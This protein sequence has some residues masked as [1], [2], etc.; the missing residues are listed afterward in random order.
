MIYK[1][2]LLAQATIR[3]LK[4]NFNLDYDLVNAALISD[5]DRLGRI[6]WEDRISDPIDLDALDRQAIL[7]ARFHELTAPLND[8]TKLREFETDFKDWIYHSVTAAVRANEVLKVFAGPQVSQG[9]FRRLCAETAEEGLEQDRE[10]IN[11][12]FNKKLDTIKD[13]LMRE[14]REL[15]EDE[16]ELSQRKMEEMGTHAQNLLGLLAGRRRSMTTSL[17]KHRMTTKAKADVE[18][19]LDMIDQYKK[20]IEDLEKDRLEKLREVEKKWQEIL[21]GVTEIPVT[22]YKKDILVE[23]FGVGWFPYYSYQDQG[24]LIELAAFTNK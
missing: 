10:K 19:S 8:G 4:R 7:D 18:E 9:E 22:P 2:V 6:R 21:E 20:E 16:V 11:D 5:P 23:L 14:E 1:P 3:F 13:R 17:T 15:K 24:K 12:S